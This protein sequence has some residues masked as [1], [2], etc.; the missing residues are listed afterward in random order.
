ML[1]TFR[2]NALYNIPGTASE[3]CPS[4]FGVGVY[5][6]SARVVSLDVMRQSGLFTRVERDAPKDEAAVNAKLLSRGGFVFKNSA[7]VYSYLPLGWRVIQKIAAIIREEMNAIGGEEILMPALVDK[8]YF[9][10]SG[11]WDVPVGFEIRGKGEDHARFSLG[12]TH[13]EVMTA[14]AKQY[15]SS[16]KDLPFSAYQIQTKFRNEPRA[17]S[18]LLRGREFIMKDLYSFH[19]SEEDFAAYYQKVIAAYHAI[20]ARCGVRAILT[21]AGGG[22][23]TKENTH[24]FQ[25]VSENGEDTIF[26]CRAC[27]YAENAEISKL[28]EGG[29]CPKCGKGNVEK[30]HSIEVGNIFPLG[31]KFAKAFNLAFLSREGTREDV[32]MGSYGIGVGRLMGAAVELHHDA[33]GILWPDAIAP[34]QVHLLELDRAEGGEIYRDLQARRIEVLYD[35]RDETPG[36]KFA[37]ADLVGIPWRMVVSKKT[38]QEG[39]AHVEMKRRGEEQRN[40]VSLKEACGMIGLST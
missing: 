13:E 26:V 21:L 30:K 15:V 34:Y 9:D 16:Y 25:A 10:A 11:R 23:F 20:F 28:T 6:V 38:K 1:D 3:G 19:A 2:L 24:E 27:E 40:V 8:K 33:K 36:E 7:G 37:E 35:D 32:V 4:Q 22:D 12:W 17:K 14:I 39:S 5:Q 18:G 31:T 29:K